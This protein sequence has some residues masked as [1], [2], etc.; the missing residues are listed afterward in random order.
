MSSL[1]L[2]INYEESTKTL[3]VALTMG[4]IYRYFNVP[5]YEYDQFL[6]AGS[7]G[8]YYNQNIKNNYE[9]TKMS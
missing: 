6:G 8:R 4:A 7:L 3:D 1:I 5:K 2:Y 9:Y